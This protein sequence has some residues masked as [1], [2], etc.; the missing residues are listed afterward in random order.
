[1]Y[2]SKQVYLTPDQI[3]KINNYK[4]LNKFESFSK[5]VRMMVDLYYE[6]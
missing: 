3:S 2:V 4:N 5:M 1:M 6:T